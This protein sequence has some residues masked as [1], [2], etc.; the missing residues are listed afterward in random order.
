MPRH[1]GKTRVLLAI[2]CANMDKKSVETFVNE[3]A[4]KMADFITQHINRKF[5]LVTVKT[6]WSPKRRGSRGGMYAKGP[7]INMALDHRYLQNRHT[8]TKWY[9]Y[10][11]FDSHTVYGGFYY[12]NPRIKLLALTAHEVAHAIQFFEQVQTGIRV[13]PHGT[14]F[15]SHYATLRKEFVNH[16]IEDQKT[17]FNEYTKAN[18]SFKANVR[19]LT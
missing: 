6:D 19:L 17:L 12:T 14:E 3:S 4:Y 13:K 15:K 18:E 11:S 5:E 1:S 9:E 7:G 2:L 16:L 10:A 8:V